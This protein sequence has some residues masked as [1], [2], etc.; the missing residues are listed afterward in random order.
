MKRVML[1]LAAALFCLGLP[2]Q[3]VFG[4]GRAPKFSSAYTDLKTQCRPTTAEEDDPQVG[5]DAPLRCEGYGGYQIRVDFSA[6]SSHLRVQPTGNKTVNPIYLAVQPLNYN[7][8]RKI[9]WRLADGKPF[10]VIFRITKARG[11]VDPA[12]MWRP[13]NKTGEYL[14]VNGLKGYEHIEFEVDARIRNANARARDLADRAF[15]K[16]R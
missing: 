15:M 5:D 16:G 13:E 4:D 10:A 9:E 1:V 11:G 7:A 14:L 6:V 12:L 8:K 3:L 2:S